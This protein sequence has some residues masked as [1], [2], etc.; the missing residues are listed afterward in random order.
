MGIPEK[1]GNSWKVMNLFLPTKESG[2]QRKLLGEP[3]SDAF[4]CFG[5][6]FVAPKIGKPPI[7]A[8]FAV[9]DVPP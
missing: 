9:A 3:C 2:T 4:F 1:S 6:K 5:R 7:R 8:K